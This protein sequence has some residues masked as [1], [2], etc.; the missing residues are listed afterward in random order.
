[1]L[2]VAAFY[3]VLALR[4]DLAGLDAMPERTRVYDVFN[5]E[6]GRLHGENRVK[7]DLK[8]VS[9]Y[10]T[11]ALLA[12]EDTRFYSHHGIDP[13]GIAR[14]TLR[15]FTRGGLREGASTLTQ[16]LARNTYPLGGRTLHR[17]LLEA[18]VAIRIEQEHTKDEILEFYINRIFYGRNLLGVETASQAYFGKTSRDLSLGQAA[19]LAGLI[20]SPNRFNPSADP[21]AA[22]GERDN[23]LARMRSL[24]WITEEEAAKAKAESVK[25]SAPRTMVSQENYAMEA[26]A[27]ELGVILDEKQIDAGG[28]R[29][30]TTIDPALQT[31][32]EKALESVI[33]RRERAS[34][35][36]QTVRNAG[37]EPSDTTPYLQGGVVVI[38]N[39]TGGI[40]A[41]V[42]GRS[43]RESRF[44]RAFYSRRQ[45]GSTIKPF[46]YASAYSSG[47]LPGTWVSDDPLR[48]GEI[49]GAPNWNPSN[50]DN[51]SLGKLAAEDGL[52]LS[53]NTVSVRIGQVA[54]LQRVREFLTKLGFRPPIPDNPSL[55]LGTQEA[56]L[57]E[58]TSAFTVFPNAG[59]KRQP[60]VITK[61]ET[62]AGQP[63]YLATRAD[64][65]ALDP[66]ATWLAARGLE[67]ALKSGTGR[68]AAINFPAAGKTGTTNDSRDVWFVG[69][70][71]SLTCGVWSGFDTPT[72]IPGAT[73]ANIA[74][75]VWAAIMQGADQRNYPAAP[76]KAPVAQT[77]VVL[78]HDS[79]ALATN[80]CYHASASY[81]D[82]LPAPFIPQTPCQV[83]QGYKIDKGFQKNPGS[84]PERIFRSI[85]RLFGGD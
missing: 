31:E 43:Y 85:G 47:L 20:R 75:P 13:R 7:V 23:V 71:S 79:G 44:N 4:Y 37:A 8:E 54:G 41:V 49:D 57:K 65:T 42:G 76:L 26:I 61:I 12:R 84:A 3:F 6:Y 70:T 35:Y 11:K 55:F 62:Q 45:V 73:G 77:T 15:I 74:L 10:F 24:D 78:C 51:R 72:P 50:Y 36:R 25:I 46:V 52:A 21:E 28:L 56:T 29:V 33:S 53:R 59:K 1:M 9:P 63:L 67:V 38:D 58:L 18:A 83:H 14:A 30:F 66:A 60:F 32:A 39:A 27:D 69:Y 80:E 64:H 19:M 17:K 2:A 5:R 22:R 81:E 82:S 16:Q 48:P 40:R 68:S 34:G